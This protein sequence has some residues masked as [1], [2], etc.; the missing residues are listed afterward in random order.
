[1][2][3]SVE[4]KERLEKEF[5]FS[6]GRSSGPGGQ[7]VNKVNTRVELRFKIDKSENLSPAEKNKI[8]IKLKNRINAA[9]ELVLVAQTE[10]SQWRNRLQVTA[11]FFKLLE[12]IL[13]P[14]KK[15]IKTSP[16]S[17]SRLKRIESKKRMGLKKQLR[18]PPEL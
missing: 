4:R 8:K 1:M 18:K 13:T 10:R 7:N 12:E 3:F 2:I 14:V 16:T 5:L 17:A 15:R 9:G 11:R 6:A